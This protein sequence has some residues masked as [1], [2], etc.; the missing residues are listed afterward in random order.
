MSSWSAASATAS[1]PRQRRSRRSRNQCAKVQAER[2]TQ[3]APPDQ[4]LISKCEQ[5]FNRG[6]AVGAASQRAAAVQ[7]LLLYSLVGLGVMGLMSGAVG[8]P[9]AG[10]AL[11]PVHAITR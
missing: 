2:K 6:V 5:G 10:R 7:Q 3:A 11:R 1:R 4:A 9:L 8:W